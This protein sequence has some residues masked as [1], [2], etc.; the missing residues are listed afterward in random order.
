MIEKLASN[1]GC[2][3]FFPEVSLHNVEKAKI[4]KKYKMKIKD[5][6][7]K[8][9]LAAAI[10]AFRNYHELFL[11]VEETLEKLNRKDIFDKVVERMLQREN[12]NIVNS[13][14]KILKKEMK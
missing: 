5:S 10:K 12:E 13:V 2:K 9:A 11:K 6:H 4:I 14:K 3:V 8:D 7:Q 1:L